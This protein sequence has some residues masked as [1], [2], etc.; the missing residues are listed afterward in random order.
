MI[1]GH[2]PLATWKDVALFQQFLADLYA[3][4]AA[5]HKAGKTVDQAVADKAWMS[6]YP[7]YDSTR[8][9][10]GRAGDLRRAQRKVAPP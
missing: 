10:S 4:T 8:L 5:A 6:K 7:G 2:Q 1:G 3:Q 9:P